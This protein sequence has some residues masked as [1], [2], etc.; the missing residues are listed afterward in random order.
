MAVP[1][2]VSKEGLTKLSA[3]TTEQKQVELWGL[4]C[5]YNSLKGALWCYIFGIWSSWLCRGPVSWKHPLNVG[6]VLGYMSMSK[7]RARLWDLVLPWAQHRR[8]QVLLSGKMQSAGTCSTKGGWLNKGFNF[9]QDYK[10]GNQVFNQ[11]FLLTVVDSRREIYVNSFKE[12]P[13]WSQGSNVDLSRA[14]F[15]LALGIQ[16]CLT[17]STFK[18]LPNQESKCSVKVVTEIS[19]VSSSHGLKHLFEVMVSLL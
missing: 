18:R 11:W 7:P 13:L 15:G 10:R 4:N 16:F 17:L 8:S 6:L 5:T 9:S 3:N 2:G 14:W 12:V 19:L 1:A